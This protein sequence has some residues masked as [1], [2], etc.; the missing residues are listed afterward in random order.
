MGDTSND[1]IARATEAKGVR[2]IDTSRAFDHIKAKKREEE[3]QNKWLNQSIDIRLLDQ[4]GLELDGCK[5]KI[6]RRKLNLQHLQ[7]RLDYAP[8]KD[9]KL[10]CLRDEKTNEIIWP[11]NMMKECVVKRTYII[12]A[13]WPD[14]PEDHSKDPSYLGD[15]GVAL[16][17]VAMWTDDWRNEVRAED[18]REWLIVA[19]LEEDQKGKLIEDVLEEQKKD[20]QLIMK[21]MALVPKKNLWYMT[22]E[23]AIRERERLYQYYEEQREVQGEK[24]ELTKK[25]IKYHRNMLK[26]ISL[27]MTQ[28]EKDETRGVCTWHI[29]FLDR[30]VG[31]RVSIK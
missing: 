1:T 3:Q 22:D 19:I 11:E 16:F 26:R 15:F 17:D 13:R 24:I 23:Q 20:M 31:E 10:D 28:V 25:R 9:V 2:K 12:V 6:P 30:T 14:Y 4:G 8:I 27:E 18:I 21:E 29:R 5:W 7:E